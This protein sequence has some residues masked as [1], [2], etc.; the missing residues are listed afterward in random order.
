M[1]REEARDVHQTLSFGKEGYLFRQM[2]LAIAVS[3]LGV[4]L[5]YLLSGGRP[6]KPGALVAVYVLICGG[7]GFAAYACWR[8]MHPAQPVLVLAPTGIR[9]R[10][11]GRLLLTIPWNEIAGVDTADIR[12]TTRGITWKQRDVPVVLVSESFYRSRVKPDTWWHRGAAWR[13]YFIPRDGAI[14][15]SLFHDVVSQPSADLRDAIERRWRAFSRHPNAQL[16][17][18]PHPARPR[19][20]ASTQAQ[21]LAAMIV[22]AALALPLL[23]HWQW[24]YAWLKSGVSDSAARGYLDDLLDRHAVT[25]RRSDGRMVLVRRWDVA[26]VGAARCHTDIA[27]DSEAQTLTPAYAVSTHCVGDLRLT[28]GM[29][30]VAIYKL[31]VTTFDVEYE[32]GKIS[33]GSAIVP[34]MLN[35]EEAER[36]LCALK[37]CVA[38]A[39]AG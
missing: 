6:A 4:G 1:T 29:A 37:G 11:D 31:V 28:N 18:A 32:L 14:Q 15:I 16:P 38:G 30:A 33:K 3:L 8:R 27:R 13:Y 2:P 21:R 20:W 17:P 22:L 12:M 23:W 34:A 7:F 25:A 5:L 36:R 19:R 39:P 9:Y 10:I 35:L 24:G 26:S